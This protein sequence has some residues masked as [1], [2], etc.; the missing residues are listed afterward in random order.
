MKQ[1]KDGG[2]SPPRHPTAGLPSPSL[3]TLFL[4]FIFPFPDRR[5]LWALIPLLAPLL[6]RAEQEGGG[7]PLA[8][9]RTCLHLR[10]YLALAHLANVQTRGQAGACTQGPKAPMRLHHCSGL[11]WVSTCCTCSDSPASKICEMS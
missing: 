9:T 6:L 11:A 5:F 2:C 8:P 7:S 4:S 10:F 3:L 1:P